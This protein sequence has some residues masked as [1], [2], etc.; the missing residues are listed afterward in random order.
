MKM[1]APPVPGMTTVQAVKSVVNMCISPPMMARW[2]V[3]RHCCQ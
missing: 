3:A 1:T 2:S